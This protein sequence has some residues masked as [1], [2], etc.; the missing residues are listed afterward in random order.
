MAQWES[1]RVQFL[2]V[3][4]YFKDFSLAGHILPTRPEPAWQKMVQSPLNGQ[5]G[6]RPKFNHGQTMVEIKSEI[7]SSLPR[8][9]DI[10]SVRLVAEIEKFL[11]MRERSPIIVPKIALMKRVAIRPTEKRM[12]TNQAVNCSRSNKALENKPWRFH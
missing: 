7:A 8:W 1:E 3:A 2:A 5:R 12:M 9:T 10:A 6:G 11:K 4:E